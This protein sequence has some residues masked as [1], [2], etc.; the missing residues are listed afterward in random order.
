[1]NSRNGLC[2]NSSG[3]P[4]SDIV[5]EI[6]DDDDDFDIPSSDIPRHGSNPNDCGTAAP[7]PVVSK[8]FGAKKQK[9]PQIYPACPAVLMPSSASH[10]EKSPLSSSVTPNHLDYSLVPVSALPRP[11]S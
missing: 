3:Y 11:F 4:V 2:F 9:S 7:A 1:M 10:P 5:E 6:S 8:Y